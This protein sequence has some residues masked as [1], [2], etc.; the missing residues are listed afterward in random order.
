[1]EKI[2]NTHTVFVKVIPH[3]D[4]M[5]CGHSLVLDGTACL[6]QVMDRGNMMTFNTVS[7]LF[8]QTYSQQFQM[9]VRLSDADPF[10]STQVA[11]LEKI[12]MEWQ[13]NSMRLWQSGCR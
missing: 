2:Q 1:M 3:S 7:N 13:R 8:Y 6:C 9:R 10:I 5:L 11:D 12:Y 4:T